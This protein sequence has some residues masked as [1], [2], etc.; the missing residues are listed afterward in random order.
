MS[1]AFLVVTDG[2]VFFGHFQQKLSDFSEKPTEDR[3]NSQRYGKTEAWNI[4]LLL[5]SGLSLSLCLCDVCMCTSGAVNTLC[6]VWKFSC[7][8][9]HSLI[10]ACMYINNAC[11][12]I[13][14]Y[15]QLRKDQLLE[16]IPP[17]SPPF[18]TFPPPPFSLTVLYKISI[19]C[20]CCCFPILVI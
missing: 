7:I 4:M 20:F 10:H 9:F 8:K 15:Q 13:L 5:L 16:E 2:G 12:F 19:D 18:P 6:F 14:T 11:N 17:P 1:Y 3:I